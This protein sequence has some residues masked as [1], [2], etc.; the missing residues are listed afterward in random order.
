MRVVYAFPT[1]GFGG[2]EALLASQ[3]PWLRRAGVDPVIVTMYDDVALLTQKGIAV[4]HISLGLHPRPGTL[5]ALR[6][7]LQLSSALRLL[8]RRL[9]PHLMHSNMFHWDAWARRAARGLTP[10]LTTWHSTDRWMASRR[11]SDRF[12]VWLE[13]REARRGEN[14]FLAV[15]R[16][17]EEWCV[18]HLRLPPEQARLIYNGIDLTSFAEQPAPRGARPPRVVMVGRLVPEKAYDVGIEAFR[19]ARDAG[20][21]FTVDI[22]GGGD[23]RDELQAR[24]DR[25]D[26]GAVVRLCGVSPRIPELL[27]GYDLYCMSSR[28][29]GLPVAPLEAMAAHLPVLSTRV[30]GCGEVV[31]PGET[32]LLTPSESPAEFASALQT[33]L[34]DGALRT[35]MGLAGRRR[36]E[37]EFNLALQVPKMVDYYRQIL[38]DWKERG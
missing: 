2:A 35:R 22:W 23:L 21:A 12:K 25:A 13:R 7:G 33:L 14:Y 4:E 37:S 16:A 29:E 32:G 18:R 1:M 30:A 11:V 36:V 8:L 20:A 10:T 34:A 19:L 3:L 5:G 6:M 28:Q 38:S 26:L 15:S 24:I 31:L 9:R 17:V 27:A